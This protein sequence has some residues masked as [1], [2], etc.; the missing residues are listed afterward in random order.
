MSDKSNLLSQDVFEYETSLRYILKLATPMMITLVSFTI[1]QF[2]DRYMVSHLGTE[3]LA[4]ILP[5]GTVS[6]VPASL[7]LGIVATLSTFVSQ[8]LG[9]GDNKDCS[10]F[11]WQA[12]YL[13]LVYFAVTI[14]VLWPS[15]YWI[16]RALG[17]EAE[18]V[19]MEVV[20]FRIMLYVHFSALII[21]CCSHFFIGTHRPHITMYSAIIGHIINVIA[22]YI[23]IFG[24][25][26]FPAMG[27]AGAAWGTFIGVTIEALIMICAFLNGDSQRI[28]KSRQSTKIDLGKM[29]SLLKI[30]FPAGISFMINV[31]FF[32]V[33]LFGLIGRFGKEALAAT[34]AALACTNI[35][36]MPIIGLKNALTATVGKSIGKDR[37]DIA[38]KQTYTCLRAGTIYVVM[39]GICFIVF[40]EP[41]MRFWSSDERVIAIGVNVFIFS[42]V[43]Q[44]FDS[45]FHIYTGALRGAGD[46]M[47]PSV[48]SAVGAA[49]ILGIGGFC[50]VSLFPELGALGPWTGAVVNIFMVMLAMHWRFKS[51]HWMK[52]DLFKHGPAEIGAGVETVIE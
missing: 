37:K 6:F 25:L 16:F 26:G 27:I 39:M 42:A 46:T 49:V 11:C 18:V 22:N 44:V 31:A 32:G 14:A 40:R 9:R 33:I 36:I 1:M 51:N 10:N 52:I 12:I 28:Y 30:G 35:S 50:M 48:V 41:L 5:A 43:F 23:L 34:S 8:C 24:H 21:W 38:V 3:A 15:A 4:A 13:G 17:H 45:I 20:Y 47:W 7:A 29:A 2:V 19:A